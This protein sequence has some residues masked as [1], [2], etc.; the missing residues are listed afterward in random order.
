MSLPSQSQ[1]TIDSVSIKDHMGD[2]G[3][4]GGL[5]L[6]C[7][8]ICYNVWTGIKLAREGFVWW[9]FVNMAMDFWTP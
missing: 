4:D 9:A 1:L 7:R 6:K 2:Q 5:I 3:I 8:E